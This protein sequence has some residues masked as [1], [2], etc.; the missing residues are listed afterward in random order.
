MIGQVLDRRYQ[1]IK[2]LERGGFGQTFLARDTKRPGNPI[3]VVKQLKPS[4]SDP[5]LLNKARELF[6]REAETLQKLGEHGQIPRL[7]AYFEENQQFYLVQEYIVG[8]TLEQELISSQPLTEAQVIIIVKELLAIL[9]FVHSHNVIHRDIKPS[10]IIRREQD[11]KLVLI[12]F[13][14]VKKVTTG[15]QQNTIVIGTPGYIP[16]EQF[17]GQPNFR[18]DIYAVGMIGI[19]ALTGIKLQPCVGGGFP[20]DSQQNLLWRQY[21]RVS[22]KPNGIAAQRLAAILTK[23]VRYNYRERYQSA[24]EALQEIQDL[25]N[26]RNATTLIPPQSSEKSSQKLSE[27]I[28]KILTFSSFIAVSLIVAI[29]IKRWHGGYSTAELPLNGKLVKSVL[30]L[31]D[32]CDVLLENIYCEK[33]VVQGKS[34]QQV[35]IEM[36]SDDFDPYLV[37]QT[38]DG[39]KL[40]VNGDISPHNWNARIAIDL[41]SDGKYLVMARTSAAGESGSYSIRAVAK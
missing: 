1:I 13:G 12:D 5:E 25:E 6:N 20:T 18:S 36:N 15:E 27:L 28:K 39:N 21:A 41:P 32:T 8:K 30:D 9:D 7:L 2:V 16:I 22:D 37:M 33:Y 29:G 34:G 40:A 23:M 19:Q 35:T 10:N 3:C 26:S 17:T 14:A 4:F 31:Q 38:P 11:C 24:Q